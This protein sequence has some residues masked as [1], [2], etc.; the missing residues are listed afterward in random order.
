MLTGAVSV[1]RW[2]DSLDETNPTEKVLLL[3]REANEIAY[4]DLILACNGDVAFG[5]IETSTTTKIP[6]G[7]AKL[8]WKNLNA[9]L[10]PQTNANKVQLMSKFA[11]S[12]LKSW[13]K[14]P[15]S[16]INDLEILR[17]RIRD[18]GHNIDDHTLII[19]I[20]NNLP[21]KYDNLVENLERN[22][23]ASQPL[24][25]EERRDALSLKFTKWKLRTEKNGDRQFEKDDEDEEKDETAL[26]AGNFKRPFEGRCNKCGKF[27]HKAANYP[28]N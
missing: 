2:N 27:G 5:I 3:A 6:N 11:N 4:N 26:I 28:T 23:G 18:C 9:K 17:N 1:P 19:H 24:T 20:L 12:S 15:D 16:W 22:I 25:L 10:M 13:R 7:D 8:A 14:D 21:E